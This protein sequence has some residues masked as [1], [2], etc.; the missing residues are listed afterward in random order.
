MKFYNII[1]L[2]IL[3]ILIVYTIFR[4]SVND[5]MNIY[6]IGADNLQ[7]YKKYL[8][9]NNQNYKKNV[10]CI[11]S[12]GCNAF[13]FGLENVNNIYSIDY[14]PIQIYLCKFKLQCI[15]KLSYTDAFYILAKGYH[16]RI[17]LLYYKEIRNGLDNESKKYWDKNYIFFKKGY[18][19]KNFYDIPAYRFIGG[20]N[21][22]EK[23]ARL[24]N[25]ES[26]Y[27]K[28][29][30]EK[31]TS[32]FTK[33]FSSEQLTSDVI[34]INNSDHCNKILDQIKD[35]NYVLNFFL[36]QN[37]TKESCPEYLKEQN[38]Y[39]LKKKIISKEIKYYFVN[40]TVSNFL[41]GHSKKDIDIS[42][43]LD[44]PEYLDEKGIDEQF[45]ELSK[46]IRPNHF[47]IFKT[48]QKN[49]RVYFL[50]KK[51]HN[52][53]IISIHKDYYDDSDFVHNQNT[54]L[55]KFT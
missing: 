23:L 1:L 34:S 17:E 46:K 54:F 38:F 53:D 29:G 37:F 19:I 3:I 47:G 21:K 9:I 43:F 18:I 52:I 11:A 30:L 8:N 10:L 28:Y 42:Y 33:M 44:Q 41:K 55:Y 49:S 15:I 7:K 5:N 45:T 48:T 12:G 40:N 27:H 39:K 4:K 32:L 51:K 2:I 26:A 50:L 13:D 16:P 36:T 25:L 31:F 35:D 24:C 20:K 6:K 14:N 22:K